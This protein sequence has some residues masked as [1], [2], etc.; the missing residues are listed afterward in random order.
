MCEQMKML[1]DGWRTVQRHAVEDTDA[2]EPDDDS[3]LHR[4]FGFALFV[5]V[6]FRKRVKYGRLQKH[7]SAERKRVFTTQLKVLENLIETDKTVLPAVIKYQDRGKMLFPHPD[8]LLLCHNCSRAM[9]EKLNLQQYSLLG[10]TI[11][12]VSS[13]FSMKCHICTFPSLPL[14]FPPPLLS[15]SIPLSAPSLPPSLPPFLP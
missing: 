13:V 4:L 6:H 3:S 1:Q 9:K 15:P 5:S 2:L 7:Y 10:W 12:S 14:F 11:I 8:L